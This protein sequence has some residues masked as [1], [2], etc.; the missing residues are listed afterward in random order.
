MLKCPEASRVPP[1]SPSEQS[2]PPK[3]PPGPAA[4]PRSPEPLLCSPGPV[5]RRAGPRRHHRQTG[6]CPSPVWR[7]QSAPPAPVTRPPFPRV[8]GLLV[9]LLPPQPSR[10]RLSLA[11]RSCQPPGRLPPPLP[12]ARSVSARG[13][14]RPAPAP[15]NS[16]RGRGRGTRTPPRRWVLGSAPRP[17]HTQSSPQSGRPVP[18]RQGPR[19]PGLSTQPLIPGRSPACSPHTSFLAPSRPDASER[20]LPP[21]LAALAAQ[22][23]RPSPQPPQT[24]GQPLGL[25]NALA[26]PC[27]PTPRTAC[28]SGLWPGLP[29]AAS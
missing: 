20:P 4:A 25:V 3:R 21:L 16:A 28:A 22:R 27:P 23:G 14:P 1:V 29:A 13:P 6:L 2:Q 18:L 24:G 15:E 26:S 19:S 7:S 12:Q 11:P 17:L 9:T 8:F 5:G 10:D